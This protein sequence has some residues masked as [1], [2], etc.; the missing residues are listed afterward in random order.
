MRET[1]KGIATH[2]RL[3]AIAGRTGT[4]ENKIDGVATVTHWDPA[5]VGESHWYPNP[6]N[7]WADVD[8]RLDSISTKFDE[9]YSQLNTRLNSI[10]SLLENMQAAGLY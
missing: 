8:T 1:P 5:N 4:A 7:S 10:Q 2:Q 9:L 3:G 6:V